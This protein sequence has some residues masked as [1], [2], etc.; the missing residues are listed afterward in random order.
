[1]TDLLKLY[2]WKGGEGY[3]IEGWINI[4]LFLWPYSLLSTL[5]YVLEDSI[6]MNYLSLFENIKLVMSLSR[7][8]SP[9]AS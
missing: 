8:L 7:V 1:M 5:L 6:F 4:W 9:R 2:L 3:S